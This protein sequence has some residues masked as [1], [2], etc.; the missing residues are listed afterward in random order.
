MLVLF[1]KTLF[2]YITWNIYFK[3]MMGL[4]KDECVGFAPRTRKLQAC[5]VQGTGLA[6]FNRNKNCDWMV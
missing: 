6:C 3:K 2:K 5:K 4:S 1:S